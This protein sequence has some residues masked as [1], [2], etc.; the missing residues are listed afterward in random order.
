MG[1]GVAGVV[2]FGANIDAP[3][4]PYVVSSCSSACDAW[5]LDGGP[6]QPS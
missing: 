3:P 2:G 4:G 1:V 5:N 6:V